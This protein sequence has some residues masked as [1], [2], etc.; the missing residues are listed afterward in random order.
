VVR[1]K[2]ANSPMFDS[3][4]VRA[5]DEAVLKRVLKKNSPLRNNLGQ[6][7]VKINQWLFHI[8]CCIRLQKLTVLFVEEEKIILKKLRR[9][10]FSI[11]VITA[12][13]SCLKICSRQILTSS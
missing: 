5:A 8:S 12:H 11:L 7:A 9:F 4:I 2:A 13:I 10:L 1:A 6:Q 3:S